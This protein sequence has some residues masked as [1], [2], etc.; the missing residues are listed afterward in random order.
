MS[1][2]NYPM[3]Q[4]EFDAAFATEEACWQYLVSARW[5]DGFRCP[6]CAGAKS[7]LNSRRL[8]ECSTCGHQVSPTAG[9]ILHKTR[10]PLKS[11]FTA[12]WWICTQKT[13]GSAR[14]LQRIMGFGSYQTAWGWLHKLRRA[15]VRVNREK[16]TGSVEVDEAFIGADEPG[17]MGRKSGKKAK[18]IVGIE[19]P[20][21]TRRTRGRLRLQVIKDFSGSSLTPFLVNNIEPGS[22]VVTDGWEGYSNVSGLGFKHRVHV[23]NPDMLPNV[24]LVI[25]LVKRWL[26]GTHQGAVR[27][28]QLQHY[29]DE[30]AFRFNRRKS[31]HVGLLF[32]R[33]VQGVCAAQPMPYNQLRA[34]DARQLER[35]NATRSAHMI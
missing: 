27:R 31:A 18:I 9:T 29:L 28:S 34:A 16:L 32:H 4:A 15:M 30:F 6:A 14:G 17:V 12:M 2:R 11:W 1:D 35:K 5:P 21:D 22:V 10:K 33:L 20:D 26:L 7:W 3:N 25:A 13:G 23:G 24:H 8:M 19:I